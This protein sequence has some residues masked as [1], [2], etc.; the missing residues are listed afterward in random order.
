MR[1]CPLC[2]S[3]HLGAGIKLDWCSCFDCGLNFNHGKQV[4]KLIFKIEALIAIARFKQNSSY[5]MKK[6]GK[7]WQ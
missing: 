2:N 3:T 5:F 4:M 6:E 7:Y 1:K